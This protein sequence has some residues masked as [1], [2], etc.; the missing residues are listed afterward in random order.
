MEWLLLPAVRLRLGSHGFAEERGP[1][2][3]LPL[4]CPAAP[5][6]RTEQGMV[7]SLR[8]SVGTWGLER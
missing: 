6:P 7:H 4:P 3:A 1:A 8:S 2:E 5:R